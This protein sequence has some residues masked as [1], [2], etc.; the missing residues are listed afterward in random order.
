MVFAGDTFHGHPGPLGGVSAHLWIVVHVH[1]PP[2]DTCELAVLVN[3]TTWIPTGDGSCIVDPGDHP[4][5]HHRSFLYY[6]EA[7]EVP[8]ADITMRPHEPVSAALLSRVRRG[9]H[10]SK[11]TAKRFKL[12]VPRT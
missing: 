8:V 6:R 3:V 4:F 11:F 12:C 5:I 2:L 1:A 10:A 7:R 9:L